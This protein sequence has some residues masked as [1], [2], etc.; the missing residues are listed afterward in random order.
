MLSVTLIC[1]LGTPR[2]A[3]CGSSKLT[4]FSLLPLKEV[5]V[6]KLYRV[7][8]VSNTSFF[9]SSQEEVV[10]G[11]AVL[12]IGLEVKQVVVFLPFSSPPVNNP[13]VTRSS[14]NSFVASW[15]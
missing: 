10:E 6:T 11:A 5:V 13:F 4:L 9:I 8:I 15:W 3:C 2:T 14:L 12:V 7:N 1:S